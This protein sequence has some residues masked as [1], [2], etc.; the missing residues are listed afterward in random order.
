NWNGV[1]FDQDGLETRKLRWL[2]RHGYELANHTTSHRSLE[3]LDAKTL[4]WE[5]ANCYRY[6][7]ARVPKATMD[8]MALPYGIAPRD[9]K[10]WDVLLHGAQGG[11]TYTNRC[12]LLAG[13][14]VSAPY[15][16]Q[17]FDPKRV[18][19]VTPAPGSIETCI[20]T[21]KPGQTET[22]FVSDGDPN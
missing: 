19:R 1:P 4:R 16:S 13:G 9:P 5:M 10:L 12:I 17:Q 15:L 6:V 7:K 22:P 20:A 21:L 8:T 2:A 18:T 11:T 3:N 14:G